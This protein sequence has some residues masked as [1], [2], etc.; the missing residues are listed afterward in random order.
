MGSLI[1]KIV[2]GLIRQGRSSGSELALDPARAGHGKARQRPNKRR[3][4]A[5]A[6]DALRW[7]I[8]RALP[9]GQRSAAAGRAPTRAFRSRYDSKSPSAATGTIAIGQA[10]QLLTSL[11][12]SVPF[13]G[14]RLP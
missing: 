11:A 3:S 10:C 5:S 12:A 8:A 13:S 7:S 2:S 1:W 9:E 4:L 6:R 14:R